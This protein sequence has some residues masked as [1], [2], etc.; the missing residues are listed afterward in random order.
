MSRALE[1][2]EFDGHL[3]LF[4]KSLYIF[5]YIDYDYYIGYYIDFIFIDYGAKV[6]E[7]YNV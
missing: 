7:I 2:G 4:H 5:I 3:Y 6:I 1:Q